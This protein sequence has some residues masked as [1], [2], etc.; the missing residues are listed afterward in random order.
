[1]RNILDGHILSC[2]LL[3]QTEVWAVAM[4]NIIDESFFQVTQSDTVF[5]VKAYV[6]QKA[7]KHRIR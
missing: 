6:I 3:V 4:M 2:I 5:R 1:M 7:F